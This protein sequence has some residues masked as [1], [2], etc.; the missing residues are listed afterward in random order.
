MV[1]TLNLLNIM[2][3]YNVGKFIFSSTCATYGNPEYLPI[4]ETHPQN[5]INPYGMSKLM[6]ENILKVTALIF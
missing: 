2:M 4:D 1:A 6:I 3:E 5:P